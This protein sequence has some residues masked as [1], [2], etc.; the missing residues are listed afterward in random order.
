VTAPTHITFGALCYFAV[1]AIAQWPVTTSAV[2][3]AAL[4]SLLPDIDL[5]TSAVG[6][7]LFPVARIINEQLGHRTLTHSIVGVLLLVLI[8]LPLFLLAPLIFWALVIGYFS[9]LLIDTE[10]KA[11]IELLY[12]SKLRAWFFKDERY[13]ITVG[14]REETILLAVLVV[15]TLAFFPVT[16]RGFTGTLHYLLGDTGSAVTDFYRYMP[17]HAVMATVAAIDTISQEEIRGEFPV[18][19]ANGNNALIIKQDG[20]LR[21]I[22]PTG[23]LRPERVR[24]R[25]G[26]PHKLVEQQIEMGGHVLREIEPFVKGHD[27]YL[28]GTLHVITDRNPLVRVDAFNPIRRSGSTLVLEYA[29]YDDLVV[30]GF[31]LVPVE[32]GTLILRI[33]LPP[34]ASV[35]PVSLTSPQGTVAVFHVKLKDLADLAVGPGSTMRK[36]EVLLRDR[37]AARELEA[38]K[39]EIISEKE[40]WGQQ[41]RITAAELVDLRAKVSQAEAALHR[42][43]ERQAVYTRSSELFAKELKKL[44]E[45]IAAQ[46]NTLHALRSDL[47]QRE[48]KQQVEELQYKDKLRDLAGRQAKLEAEAVV[49]STVT[50]TVIGMETEH[51]A[52]NI[53]VKLAVATAKTEKRDREK[54]GMGERSLSDISVL[55]MEDAH[56]QER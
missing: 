29:T 42:L 50:G 15:F 1:A 28:F 39:A 33:A 4:G 8:L 19:G 30:Q 7:P 55:P 35:R 38:V 54:E 32:Q 37:A 21:E 36:G 26:E 24:I 6:R 52:E 22:G 3:T 27:V 51:G 18:L 49:F 12:P 48:T 43:T 47:A 56:G 23:H 16:I 44:G 31:D 13:R 9:H 45:E 34:D 40:Q 5:P 53:T 14:S 17:S 2:A 20:R 10:N 25:K 11:G 41:Q 46:D